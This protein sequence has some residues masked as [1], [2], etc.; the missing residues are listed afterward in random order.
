MV[1]G[2][3]LDGAPESKEKHKENK[4]NSVPNKAVRAGPVARS[5]ATAQEE[6]RV[7]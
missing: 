5:P 4:T 2:G 7:W 3:L 1:G 6:D